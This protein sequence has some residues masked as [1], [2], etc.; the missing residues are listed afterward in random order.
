MKKSYI[1][2]SIFVFLFTQSLF[3]DNE[4]KDSLNN[5]TGV[6][7][8]LL[9]DNKIISRLDSVTFVFFREPY[10]QEMP[11]YKAKFGFEK[12]FIPEYSDSVYNQRISNMNVLSPFEFVFNKNVNRFIHFY[13]FKYR[14][15]LPRVM[16][17]SELYFP[18]FDEQLDKYALP[19][20]LKYVSIIE[21]ALNPIAKSRA[22]ATGLWQFMFRT[23]KTYG[24]NV[25][26]YVDDRCDPYKSTVAACEHFCDLYEI[27][28]DW[29]LVLAAYNAGAGAVNRA[30]RRSGGETN[31]WKIQDK[32]PR[33]TQEYVPRFI[34]V[35]YLMIY[36]GEHN[37]YPK[38]ATISD[39]EIDSITVKYE[40]S[41][42]TISDSLN[43]PYEEIEILNPAY[44]K[45]IIPASDKQTYVL[46]LPYDKILDFIAMENILYEVKKLQEEERQ[47]LLKEEMAN[48]TQQTN[49]NNSSSSN[50]KK[51][52]HKV[53]RGESL[54][55]IAEKYGCDVSQLKRWN[56]ISGTRINTDQKLIVYES[57][58]TVK[59]TDNSSQVQ[60][61]TSN[62]NSKSSSK[63]QIIYYTVKDG[64]SLWAIA[65]KYEGATI[66]GIKK[67]NNLRGSKLKIEQKLKIPV[68]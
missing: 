45:G 1:I 15:Y 43:I 27:Y 29:N 46:R 4:P 50:K 19:L 52:T 41:F 68:N 21:S 66:E 30:I 16:A 49:N 28:G 64:D 34:A 55:V 11:D 9:I 62:I 14:E 17:M 18:L 44:C 56:N 67:M 13:G 60:N 10:K 54:S 35:A 65:N 7:D 12:E 5:N 59:K 57:S 33:E 8:T 24:L 23:G 39:Y 31:Y 2:I 37:I 38:V 22:G 47:R 40:L 36:A 3:A 61:N 6:Q 32:L 48:N 58:T 20:E 51:S 63:Q 53:R 25:T 26:S 42:Q